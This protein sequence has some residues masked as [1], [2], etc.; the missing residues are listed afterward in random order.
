MEKVLE[1]L[2]ETNSILILREV[3]NRIM[4]LRDLNLLRFNHQQIPPLPIYRRVCSPCLWQP[5]NCFTKETL[6]DDNF[7]SFCHVKPARVLELLISSPITWKVFVTPWGY[8]HSNTI[9]SVIVD[10]G[11]ITHLLFRKFLATALLTDLMR[12]VIATRCT[13]SAVVFLL[14][15]DTFAAALAFLLLRL[16]DGIVKVLLRFSTKLSQ[17]FLPPSLRWSMCDRRCPCWCASV[18]WS[19][20]SWKQQ[21]PDQD[22][23]CYSHRCPL[24]C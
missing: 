19:C 4:N 20:R 8:F 16:V 1:I 22:F 17:I 11:I 2:F 18:I 23:H 6:S 5:V 14:A 7:T 15:A 10:K 3:I 9:Y 24:H 12:F 21:Q 13:F